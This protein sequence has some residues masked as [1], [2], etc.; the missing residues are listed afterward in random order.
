MEQAFQMGYK[1]G[2]KVFYVSHR[3]Q[4]GEEEFF[5]DHIHK[6]DIHWKVMNASFEEAPNVDEI[7]RGSLGE[8]YLCGTTTIDYK[9]RCHVY[10]EMLSMDSIFALR[11]YG[12]GPH[13]MK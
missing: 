4:K 2:D 8:C 9:P 5:A 6:W 3:N 13:K 12:C 11:A 7:W 1:K 10:Q